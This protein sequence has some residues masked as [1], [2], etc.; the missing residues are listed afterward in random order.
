VAKTDLDPEDCQNVVSFVPSAAVQFS[1]GTIAF[2]QITTALGNPPFTYDCTTGAPTRTSNLPAVI[3]D[4]DMVFNR[5]ESF[6]TATPTPAGELDVFATASHEFGHLLG[7]DHSGIAHT[8]MFPYGEFGAGQQRV[9]AVDDVLG[10]AFLYPGPAF[11][12]ATGVLSG[13]VT[14]EGTGIF[15][16]H[17]VAA[18]KD[19][20]EA[21]IDGL[22][23]PDGIYD[24]IGVPPGTYH[25]LALP[26]SGVYDLSGF[27]GWVCGFASNTDTC[28]GFP[29]NPTDFTGAFH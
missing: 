3:I 18:D 13:R 7:L 15:A 21:V 29:Q 22:T 4:A 25:V 16:A 28:T 19:T 17:V 6:S 26:L 11:N 1:T 14:L 10:V 20:G 2:T 27:S 12:T 5:Q 9:L 8:M 24:L 23:N